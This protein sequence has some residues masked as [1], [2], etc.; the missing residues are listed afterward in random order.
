MATERRVRLTDGQVLRVARVAATIVLTPP[1]G[2]PLRL[3]LPAAWQLA[4]AI[5]ALATEA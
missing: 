1:S 5:D 4:E 3:T 2:P